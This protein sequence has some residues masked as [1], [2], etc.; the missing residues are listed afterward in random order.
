MKILVTLD[1]K[2]YSQK[3]IKD[4][5]RLAGN[6]LADIV[7]LG[8]QEDG[9][10]PAKTLST[11]LLKYHHDLC[12][13]F[14]PDESP[15]SEIQNAEWQKDGAGWALSSR[16]MK[17]CTILIRT[18]S[19]AQQTLSVA[20]EVDSDLIIL[21]CSRKF[22]C[23]WDG[24]MNVPLRIARDAPCSVLVI[25][26]VKKADQIIS[27]LDQSKVSQDAL[28]LVNQLVTLHDAGLKIVGVKEKKSRKN[29][30]IEKK[31]VELLKYYNEREISA[32]IKLINADDVQ[33]YVTASSREGIVALW[34]GGKESLIKKLFSRSMVDRLLETTRSALL[35]LR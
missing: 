34:M 21:G 24:E 19:V 6:T 17:E 8:V 7:L 1:T 15:Y 10:K 27:I 33:D 13:Y 32:W 5:A 18:G 3:I 30:K 2:Q 29:S 28:E 26:A 9:K 25:K 23:E 14:G 12:G 11:A 20:S 31:M 22:G 35:I 4:V 16:G